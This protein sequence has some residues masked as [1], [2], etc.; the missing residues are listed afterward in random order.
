MGLIPLSLSDAC[1]NPLGNLESG[2][3]CHLPLTVVKH[4]K[5]MTL[6]ASHH[7]VVNGSEDRDDSVMSAYLLGLQLL[8]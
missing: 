6:L 7:T 1:I 8:L 2:Y 4:L 5:E 3:Y